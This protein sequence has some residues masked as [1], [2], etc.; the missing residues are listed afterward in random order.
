MK[1]GVLVFSENLSRK[2]K[3]YQNPTKITGTL[4]ILCSVTFFFEIRA[5]FEIMSKIVVYPDRL[6]MTIQYGACA[7]HAR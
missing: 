7:L 3:L 5:V 6:Q 4:H 1:F 2:F